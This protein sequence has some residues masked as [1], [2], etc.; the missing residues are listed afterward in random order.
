MPEICA[1]PDTDDYLRLKVG[2]IV[3]LP[4]GAMMVVIDDDG[5]YDKPIANFCGELKRLHYTFA[6]LEDGNTLRL[7]RNQV[8][9]DVFCETWKVLR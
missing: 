4:S 1:S 5:G 7:P 9:F 8:A 6:S 3:E 2:E